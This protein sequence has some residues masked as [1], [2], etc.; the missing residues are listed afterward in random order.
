MD[1]QDKTYDRSHPETYNKLQREINIEITHSRSK[2][3]LNRSC[4]KENEV[5]QF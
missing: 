3:D 4:D 1:D 2:D 5:L